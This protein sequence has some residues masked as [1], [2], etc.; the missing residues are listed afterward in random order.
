MPAIIAA[1]L[2]AFTFSFDDVVTS[3]FLQ[4]TA[5]SPLPIVLFGLIRFRLT[6]E[7]NAIGV[8]VM[9][10]H[11]RPDE[12]RRDDVRDRRPFPALREARR[13]PRHVPGAMSM[14]VAPAGCA[15]AVRRPGRGAAPEPRDRRRRVLLDH[16]PVRLRQD[17]DAADDRRLRGAHERDDLGQRPR[18]H[19]R[20]AV[21][22]AGQHG[23]PE[24]RAVPAP[25]RVRERRLRPARGASAR[26]RRSAS[27]STRRSRSCSSA[28]ARRRGPGS[29]PAASSSASRSPARSSTGPRC[30][31]STSR[32]ARST[33]SCA[34]DMQTE[35]KDLQRVRR[36]HVLLRHA[37]SGRGLLDVRPRRGHEPRT[38]RAGR[39]ARGGL[40]PA[41][42]GIRRRLRR[43]RQPAP[44]RRSRHARRRPATASRSPASAS[45]RSPGPERSCRTER[46]HRRRPPGGPQRRA[47]ATA[48]ASGRR[49]STSRFS[50]HS[51]RCASKPRASGRSW[52][53]R[54]RP[55][56]PS[57]AARR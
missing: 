12:P 23:V 21:P 11:G 26:R 17:D 34:R 27:A 47:A 29:S 56:M 2:L 5:Q 54:A 38:A 8:L 36:H 37:R 46:R 48:P 30:C 14:S 24:L 41:A 33:S 9:L 1:G 35:L 10:L 49:S 7:V 19:E 6:P 16:R 52:R 39:C 44:R 3:F 31:C 45:A 28:G 50:A 13:I 4:G 43:R 25:R 22:A 32:W 15:Q 20:A 57:S 55:A 40:P 18:R 53:P 42:I 51:G